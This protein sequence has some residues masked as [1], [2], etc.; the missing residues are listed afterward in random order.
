MT[1]QRSAWSL[2]LGASLLGGCSYKKVTLRCT[3]VHMGDRNRA[4]KTR[5]P[6]LEAE[7]PV[8]APATEPDVRAPAAEPDVQAP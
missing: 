8:A 6:Q 2:V 7:P 5:C 3:E 4:T 1:L